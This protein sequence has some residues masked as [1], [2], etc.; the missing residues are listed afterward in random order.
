MKFPR[1]WHYRSDLIRFCFDR[2]TEATFACPLSSPQGGERFSIRTRHKRTYRN[3]S[4]N[5][6][7]RDAWRKQAPQEFKFPS[8][9]FQS[10]ENSDEV[11]RSYPE[12]PRSGRRCDK[13][14]RSIAFRDDLA[15]SVRCSGRAHCTREPAPLRMRSYGSSNG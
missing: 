15:R 8:Q 6:G 3:G 13:T 9:T 11:R 12:N 2:R 14:I 1:L 10:Y 5:P 7:T 4:L